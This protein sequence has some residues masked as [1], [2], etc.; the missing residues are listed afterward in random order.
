MSAL[1]LTLILFSTWGPQS[2][3]ADVLPGPIP[4]EVVRVID[5][6]S[7]V[8]QASIWPGQVVSVTVRIS[9]IDT[10]EKWAS[11]TLAR[12]AAVRAAEVTAEQTLNT[13]VSLYD[14]RFGKY[15]GRVVARVETDTG[16]DL[17]AILLEAGL[18]K[19]YENG[20]RPDWCP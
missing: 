2:L 11:C 4:A 14:V 19:P 1:G 8:V 13:N 15:A 5:G 6:D 18:A 3:A 16:L 12:E 9:G 17:A 20:P 7:L 10:A